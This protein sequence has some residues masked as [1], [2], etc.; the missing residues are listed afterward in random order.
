MYNTPET[1]CDLLICLFMEYMLDYYMIVL[2]KCVSL[3][4]YV[5]LYYYIRVVNEYNLKYTYIIF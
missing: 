2:N 5:I 3:P 4:N 1:A